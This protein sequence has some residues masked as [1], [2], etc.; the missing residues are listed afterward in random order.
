VIF[1]GSRPA[2][3]ATFEEVAD[4]IRPRLAEQNG[5]ER[6]LQTL[7]DATYIEIRL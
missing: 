5:I 4:Q 2:G 7:R 6:Y 1:E 3:V